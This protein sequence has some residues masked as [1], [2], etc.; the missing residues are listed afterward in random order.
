[1]LSAIAA[2]RLY[3]APSGDSG[4]GDWGDGDGGEILFMAFL[5]F[6]G[7]LVWTMKKGTFELFDGCVVDTSNSTDDSLFLFFYHCTAANSGKVFD[8]CNY[9]VVRIL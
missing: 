1:M 7:E 8:F 3:S 4:S 5:S 2:I 6:S 9:T